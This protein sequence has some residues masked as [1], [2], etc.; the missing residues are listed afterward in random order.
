MPARTK[1]RDLPEALEWLR[2]G[3]TYQWIADEYVRKYGV[4][5]TVSMWAVLRRRH[6]IEPRIVR[7][8]SLIPWEVRP[9][10]RHGHAVAMLRAEARRRTGVRLKPKVAADLNAWLDRLKRDGAVVLYDRSAPGGWRYVPRR[11]GVD[12][13]LIR[14]PEA[15]MLFRQGCDDRVTSQIVIVY[16]DGTEAPFDPLLLESTGSFG[17]AE[18]GMAVSRCCTKDGRGGDRVLGRNPY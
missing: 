5:T 18:G 2:Q 6:G 15:A 7:D 1:V 16:D 3:R 4:E 9:E 8:R 10:H 12:L 17:E 11:D 13:D 14:E